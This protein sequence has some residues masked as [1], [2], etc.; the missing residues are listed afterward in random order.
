M[1]RVRG[2]S[3]H[4]FSRVCFLLLVAGCAGCR[5]EPTGAHNRAEQNAPQ[6]NLLL[7][8]K[9]FQTTLIPNSYEA[10]GP[11]VDPPQSMFRLIRY[12]TEGGE[13]AAY[14][15]PDPGDGDIPDIRRSE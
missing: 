13:L 10:D 7:A 9:G 15:T 11:A 4:S 12:Q 1:R 2:V 3:R 14:I 8:R 6:G 5:N